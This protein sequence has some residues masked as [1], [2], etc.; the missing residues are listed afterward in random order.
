M[1]TLESKFDMVSVKKQD[2][3]VFAY[4]QNYLNGSFG[5]KGSLTETE[6]LITY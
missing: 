1:V 6:G 4:V 3:N 5:K 2:G